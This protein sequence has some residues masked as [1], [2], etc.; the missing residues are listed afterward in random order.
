[1]EVRK[2]LLAKEKEFTHLRDD[3]SRQRREMPWVKVEKQYEFDAAGG[4]KTLA[5]LFENRSQLIVYHFMFSPKWEDG[6]PHCSFW[7]DN[8]N[9]IVVHLNHRDVT[10][11]AISRAPLDKIERFKKRMGWNFQWV[12]SGRSDFNHDYHASFTPEQ[13]KSGDVVYNYQKGG[14]FEDREGVSVFYKDEGGSIYHTYSA[15]ARGIDLMNTA[16]NYLDLAPKGRDEDGLEFNQSWV[17]YHDHY[18]D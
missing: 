10:F 7:A 9:P 3:L 13:I 15:Y 6:C 1:L 2:A 14:N 5:D 8:F 16:Y 11:V 12:S 18:E 17:R 4:T